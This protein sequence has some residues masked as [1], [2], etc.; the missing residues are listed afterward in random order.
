MHI[1]SSSGPQPAAT[2]G[3]SAH[4]VVLAV[5]MLSTIALALSLPA[6]LSGHRAGGVF[7]A[8]KVAADLHGGGAPSGMLRHDGIPLFFGFLEFDWEPGRIPGF[9]PWAGEQERR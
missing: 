2:P 8:E 6:L 7:A 3:H 1:D 5:T 4:R 9:G